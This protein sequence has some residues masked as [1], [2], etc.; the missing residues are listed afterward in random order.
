[1]LICVF[2]TYICFGVR[3]LFT[4]HYLSALFIGVWRVECTILVGLEPS[5]VLCLIMFVRMCACLSVFEPRMAKGFK[6][7]L[8]IVLSQVAT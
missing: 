3:V 4:E 8:G 5:L 6:L 2:E 7:G 1:M